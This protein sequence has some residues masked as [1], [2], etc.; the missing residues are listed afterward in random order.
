RADV[1]EPAA[2]PGDV[3]PGAP[4]APRLV[5]GTLDPVVETAA[6]G[7]VGKRV[8]ADDV[9]RLL[10]RRPAQL[11]VLAVLAQSLALAGLV[12]QAHHGLAGALEL[13]GAAP[14]VAVRT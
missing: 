8:A 6:A 7:V 13:T 12:D 2:T 3:L 4:A 10:L 11:G 1:A 5:A 9:A 14:G